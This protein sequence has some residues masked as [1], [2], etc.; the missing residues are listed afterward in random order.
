M[1]AQDSIFELIRT[2]NIELIREW[3]AENP[4]IAADRDPH[5]ISAVLYA[6][7]RSNMDIVE[8]LLAANPPLDLFDAA[9]LGVPEVVLEALRDD[10]ENARAWSPDGFT[11]LHLAAYFSQP[12]VVDLLLA[13]GAEVRAA[14][15]NPMLLTALHSAVA[16]RHAGITAT[17]LEHGADPNATQA[18]GWT[19][20]HTAAHQ[21]DLPI[22]EMLLARGADRFLKGDDGRD[23]LA[24]AR[25]K[26]HAPV[27]DRLQQA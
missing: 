12:E 15:R 18:G 17:L 19:A 1:N 21:G 7:Y 25:E 22:V 10:P 9:A 6:R 14:A 2:S 5:G 27:V 4:G 26:N 20:L 11:A 3:V 23:A 13:H 24:M 16:A 8:A